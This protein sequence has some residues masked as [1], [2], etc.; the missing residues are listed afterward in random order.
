MIKKKFNGSSSE[1][2]TSYET[3]SDE[4]NEWGVKE[5]DEHVDYDSSIDSDESE[6]TEDVEED[7]DY[8]PSE[9]SESTDELEEEKE[10]QAKKQKNTRTTTIRIVI[11]DENPEKAKKTNKK[12][13]T[14]K[15][16]IL[17]EVSELQT[18]QDLIKILDHKDAEKQQLLLVSALKELE[19]M[20]GMNFLKQQI[21]NQVLFFIQDMYEPGTFL[22]TVI[23]G[24]PGTG[25][26]SIAHIMS[27][28]YR[29]LG[30]L[31]ND[32]VI[33]AD[34]ANLIGMYLGHTAVQTKKVLDSA[35]GGI[36]LIDEAYSLG[37]EEGKDSF[38]KECID[39][40]NQY[41]SEHCDD[42]IC[43]IAGYKTEIENCF[44]KQNSGLDRRFPWR[45]NID[46]YSPEDLAEIMNRQIKNWTL[47][48]P[49]ELIIEKF[50]EHIEH[51]KGNGG[52]TLNLLDKC[53]VVHAR[54]AFLD[55]ASNRK[56]MKKIMSLDKLDNLD[57]LGLIKKT[58]AIKR[59]RKDSTK[60]TLEIQNKTLENDSTK[61][62][63]INVN[64]E[65]NSE[66]F[67]NGFENFL[68]AKRDKDSKDYSKYEKLFLVE[69]LYYSW[70]KP[71]IIV[72]ENV[73]YEEY[74]RFM[75]KN[76]GY[77]LESSIKKM[78]GKIGFKEKMIE[79]EGISS[80]KNKRGFVINT[81]N[82]FEYL[83]SQEYVT[84]DMKIPDFNYSKHEKLFLVEHF[85]DSWFKKEVTKDIE[86]VYSKYEKFMSKN[87]GHNVVNGRFKKILGLI[88]FTQRLLEFPGF[89][90][91][92]RNFIIDMD[93]LFS[94]FLEQ[95]YVTEE[96]KT[97][98]SNYF[99]YEQ[100]FLVEY[101]R[102]SWNEPVVKIDKNYIYDSYEKFLAKN[103]SQDDRSKKITLG[104]IDFEKKI[105]ELPG[106][107]LDPQGIKLIMDTKIIFEHLLE[108]KLVTQEMK[109]VDNNIKN[110]YI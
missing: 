54:R 78:L 88:D 36:V 52:D 8:E 74:D 95:K 85:R 1:E 19:N 90:L 104:L 96:M 87:I 106:I 101:L 34:R 70:T 27:K 37:S 75:S 108:Q 61:K 10:P 35:R 50:K 20:V 16:F 29:S 94:Y 62:I 107:E 11:P 60:V 43:I 21:V 82:L 68:K 63:Q 76:V 14:A 49:K 5:G 99:K 23:T 79:M 40:I 81:K 77:N 48:V 89:T 3:D 92:D 97:P 46:K 67:I 57:K 18:L 110:L 39:T 7:P 109:K 53:K 59:K 6:K 56:E 55:L 80:D 86:S 73:F 44:F 30:F 32:K 105:T 9:N 102:N 22:H 12:R 65:L 103:V 2:E 4:Y 28:I 15:D 42:L 98:D 25:K 33:I 66:D 69:Y 47:N 93:K 91:K 51:F 17:N 64:R 84:E 100:L 24:P 31:S 58:V 26:T 71:E 72:S 38:S 41:L 45:F 13:V 83:K